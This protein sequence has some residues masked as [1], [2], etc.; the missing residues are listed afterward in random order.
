MARKSA[1][2]GPE[3]HGKGDKDTTNYYDL[4]IPVI[5]HRFLECFKASLSE[6]IP[7]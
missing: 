3:Y 4:L 2:K 6:K 7:Q 5:L 1:I